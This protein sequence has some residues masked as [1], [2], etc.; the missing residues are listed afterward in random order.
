MIEADDFL[1][2]L[3]VALPDSQALFLPPLE[4]I[5]G[6]SVRP[7]SPAWTF[8]IAHSEIAKTSGAPKSRTSSIQSRRYSAWSCMASGLGFVCCP[9]IQ[10][11]KAFF[12]AG[13]LYPS[14]TPSNVRAVPSAIRGG[15]MVLSEAPIPL[16]LVSWVCIGKGGIG[17]RV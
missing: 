15:E 4:R 14:P 16:S 9:L 17:G 10:P 5:A 11:T 2:T 7:I 8:R 1:V 12:N 13:C 3:E 6:V